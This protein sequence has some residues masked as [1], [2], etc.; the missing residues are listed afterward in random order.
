MSETV[1]SRSQRMS[2]KKRKIVLSFSVWQLE[3]HPQA[4]PPRANDC[5]GRRP[6]SSTARASTR[7]ASTA[8][9]RRRASPARPSTGTSRARRTSS[10]P[11]SASRM[12]PSAARSTRR[13]RRPTTPKQLV[14]LVIEGLADD[15]GRLHTRGCPFINAAA[16]YPDADSPRAPGRRRAPRRGSAASSSR[17]STAAGA[18][19][20]ATAAAQLV[21]LRDAAMVGGLPRR[22]GARAP[23]VRECRDPRGRP[24][25]VARP[26]LPRPTH[27]QLRR[28]GALGR[29]PDGWGPFS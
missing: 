10:R 21:L 24:H 20:P 9:S 29:S 19:D 25:S 13:T 16:E 11:T 1:R 8:S 23:R 6:S 3:P 4:P 28:P 15:V 5:C 7:S 27:V 14:G 18:A 17:C 22:L 2:S 12:R 26:H